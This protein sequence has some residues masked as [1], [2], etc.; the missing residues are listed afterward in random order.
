MD[1]EFIEK[2][3][4]I[5]RYLTGKLPIK[6][7]HDFE[8]FCRDHPHVLEE[9]K[10]SDRLHAGM[11]LLDMSGHTGV[12]RETKPIWWK[13]M[14]VHI[15]VAALCALSLLGLWVLGARY[16]ARGEEIARL[17]N[18]VA[19]GP[20]KAPSATRTIKT[21]PSRQGWSAQPDARILLNE[22]PDLVELKINVSFAKFNAFRLTLD[23]KDGTRIGTIHNMLRDSNGELRLQINTSGMYPGIYR[24]L[25]EGVSG[26]GTLTPVAWLKVQA[27]E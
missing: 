22:P 3:Q 23:T 11:R 8:R 24:V 9:L 2:N 21:N 17:E 5:E 18:V 27:Y 15:G 6:G 1:K 26:R 10:F 12:F 16:A 4:I 20:L 25:I 14:E 19:Q 7:V 13:R